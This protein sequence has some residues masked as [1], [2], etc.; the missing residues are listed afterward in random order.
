MFPT[1]GFDEAAEY[2][3]EASVLASIDG[4]VRA[5]Q[6]VQALEARLAGRA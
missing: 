2:A 4:I 6:R 5:E 1:R 3:V